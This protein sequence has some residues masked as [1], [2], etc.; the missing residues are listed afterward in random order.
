MNTLIIITLAIA[1]AFFVYTYNKEQIKIQKALL[2]K[3]EQEKKRLEKQR[4]ELKEKKQIANIQKQKAL[5]EK[6]EQEQKRLNEKR[7]ELERKKQIEETQKQKEIK[8]KQE[9]EKKRQQFHNKFTINENDYLT[10]D[11]TAFYHSDYHSGGKWKIDGTIENM[12]WTLKNDASPFPFRLVN[13]RK[14]LENILLTDLPQI[15]NSTNFNNFTVCVV[16]RAKKDS[17]YKYDQLYFRKCICDVVDK[18]ND[19]H[20]GTDYIKRHTNTRTTHIKSEV[21]G[22]GSLPFIGITKNT[23]TISNEVQNKDI[24][25]IDDIYTKSVNIDEDAI[26]ALF[27]NGAKSVTF[28]AI[29]K[30]VHRF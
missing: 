25:L 5:K 8:E 12:I 29:G 28:Y 27:D 15:L 30:T 9:L 3:Q 24:L 7:L 26:Q 17:Y 1:L 4:A 14:R 22:E 11:I 13:S 6:Q 16:P 23:C 21:G 10:K 19:F 20:N 18:L 2:E